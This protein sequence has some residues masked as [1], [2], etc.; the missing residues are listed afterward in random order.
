MVHCV[1]CGDQLPADRVEWGYEYCVNPGCVEENF[2][3][4]RLVEVAVN[5]SAPQVVA[6][7]EVDDALRKMRD[8]EYA[9]KDTSL[10]A[11]GHGQAG[12]RARSGNRSVRRRPAPARTAKRWTPQQERMVQVFNEMG[13]RPREM[14]ERAPHL[15]LTEKLI[16]EI[17]CAIKH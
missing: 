1:T 3:G 17:I 6:A 2:K 12:D 10:G 8:G 9:K 7:G 16:T 4:V 14:I 11:A 13:L 15:R 5:K